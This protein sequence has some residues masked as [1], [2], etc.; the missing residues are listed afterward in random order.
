MSPLLCL[1][2]T[3]IA[4]APTPE[5]TGTVVD[6]HGKPV[7]GISVTALS[8]P[9]SLL[10][11]KAV[12]GSDGSFNFAGLANGGYGLEAKADDSACAFSDAI[13]VDSGFTSV[14]RLRLVKGLCENPV[15]LRQPPVNR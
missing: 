13:Q 11:A 8:L 9:S 4:I 7:A 15:E 3:L 10:V 1:V 2:L 12:S 6:D 5:I 14:V